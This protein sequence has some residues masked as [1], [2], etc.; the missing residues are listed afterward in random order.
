MKIAADATRLRRG[1]PGGT[2]VLVT[3]YLHSFPGTGDG[4]TM[5]LDTAGQTVDITTSGNTV[6]TAYTDATH[7]CSSLS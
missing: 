7:G 5:S 3:T 4:Y 6:P 2:G 1:D